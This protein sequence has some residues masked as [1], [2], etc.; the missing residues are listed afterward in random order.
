MIRGPAARSLPRPPALAL[1]A[2]IALAC[3]RPSPAHAQAATTPES[4]GPEWIEPDSPL[5]EDLQALVQ[6]G[7]LPL[8]DGS[9]L[10][11]TRMSMA[12]TLASQ[13]AAWLSLPSGRRVARALASELHQLDPARATQWPEPVEPLVKFDLAPGTLRLRP[14]AQ[15]DLVAKDAD[16]VRWGDRARIGVAGHA[17]WGDKFSIHED[18]FAGN[19]P[20]GLEY[21]D[22]LVAHTDFLLLTESF[23]AGYDGGRFS[24]R[25]G[26]MRQALGAIPDQ[27]LLLSTGAEPFD[28]LEY[29]LRARTLRFSSTAGILSRSPERNVAVHRL[30]WSPTNQFEFAL[31]EGVVYTGGALHP[32][33]LAGFIPYT[34]VERLDGQDSRARRDVAKVRNNV[35]MQLDATWRTPAWSATASLLLDDVSTESNAIPTRLGA[36][37]SLTRSHYTPT[38]EWRATLLAAK[39][40]D[41]TYQVYYATDCPC[42]WSHQDHPLGYPLGPDVEYI[43]AE[44]EWSPT[45][46]WRL[47]TRAAYKRKGEGT[48]PEQWDLP[49]DRDPDSASDLRGVVETTKTLSADLRYTPVEDWSIQL[50]AW[51]DSVDKAHHSREAKLERASFRT[52]VL[53]H[54]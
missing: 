38:G 15:L 23:Y 4:F 3:L 13:D 2:A 45:A 10:P 52:S 53:W 44:A 31:N 40:Y 32:L 48:L 22:A 20:G 16:R 46:N 54:H 21:A 14:Y 49:A 12:R 7:V 50:G 39:V 37:A 17:S 26:R 29:Q 41:H 43:Q 19:V 35:L 9:W 30:S 1:A 51:L 25:L 6:A 24:A 47:R 5:A 8:P 42:A 36:L 34:I 18:L 28:H 27:S 33:Y 11:V